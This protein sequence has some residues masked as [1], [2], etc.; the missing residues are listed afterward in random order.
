MCRECAYVRRALDGDFPQDAIY[1]THGYYVIIDNP[2]SQTEPKEKLC[3]YRTHKQYPL[4]TFRQTMADSAENMFPD[5]K[6][7]FDEKHPPEHFFFHIKPP[8]KKAE[9]TE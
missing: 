6:I 8:R 1:F 9:K 3:I 7:H 2:T 5:H 4:L